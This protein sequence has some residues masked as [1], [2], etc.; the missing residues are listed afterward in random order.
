MIIPQLISDRA[1]TGFDSRGPGRPNT[2]ADTTKP[3]GMAKYLNLFPD[4]RAAMA[5]TTTRGIAA[6]KG[7][8]QIVEATAAKPVN[9]IRAVAPAEHASKPGTS[10]I[11]GNKAGD[12]R[13]AMEHKT[14]MGKI[15]VPCTIPVSINKTIKGRVV[16]EKPLNRFTAAQAQKPESIMAALF[17]L[18]STVIVS[19]Q[20]C[21]R[22]NHT[23]C[24]QPKWFSPVLLPSLNRLV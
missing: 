15:E 20:L 22:R 5:A 8:N 4:A 14:A 13:P 6:E 18:S 21:L 19:P 2:N 16:G 7:I 3:I 10:I 12:A 11:H 9:L 24:K 1:K 23:E 17:L